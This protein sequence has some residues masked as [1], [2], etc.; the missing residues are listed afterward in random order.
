MNKKKYYLIYQVTNNVNGKIYIGIH[1]TNDLED[2]YM[3][4]GKILNKAKEKYGLENFTFKV[5]MYLQ[6][7]E[8][9]QLLEHYVV[10]PEFCAREDVYNIKEGGDGG[11]NYVNLSSDYRF[12]SE[13]RKIACS[14]ASRAALQNCR[15]LHG[16]NAT[17]FSVFLESLTDEEYEQYR[18]T[19][20][21][22]MKEYHKN[23]PGVVAG[24]N[25]PRYGKKNSIHTRKCVSE[26]MKTDANFMKNAH[27]YV[28]YKTHQNIILHD[29]DVIPEGFVR[30]YCLDFE[31]YERKQKEQQLKL[32]IK[33]Q[34]LLDRENK[35]HQFEIDKQQKQI[36]QIQKIENIKKEL[37]EMREWYLMYGWESTVQHFNYKYTQQNF[38]RKYIKYF[39]IGISDRK[40]KK[41]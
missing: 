9:M 1:E 17:N 24:K 15:S 12:G 5:L 22:R 39:G 23:H 19:M 2:D 3:G 6:N 30:G 34:K 20:S 4:S 41:K 21:N 31:K 11:W 16:D 25:N 10:T 35:K 40:I 33:K 26:A 8:E 18:I 14:K 38:S 32:E 28:N 7:R 13:K 29:N 27:H 37:Q 36:Q